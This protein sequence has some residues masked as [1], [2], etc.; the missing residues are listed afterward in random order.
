MKTKSI[1]LSLVA[2]LAF[3]MC[4]CSNDITTEQEKVENLEEIQMQELIQYVQD[5]RPQVMEP[6]DAQTRG[7]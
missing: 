4:S 1:F 5:L 3:F 6:I 2:I 7:W